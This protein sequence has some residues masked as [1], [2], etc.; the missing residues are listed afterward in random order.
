MLEA[1]FTW[2]CKTDDCSKYL[3]PELEI[4]SKW[5]LQNFIYIVQVKIAGG[6][7]V[8]VF[9][10]HSS[11]PGQRGFYNAVRKVDSLPIHSLL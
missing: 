11:F 1:Y 7:A 10:S 3:W 2:F 5:F 9:K 8:T 4:F 6:L